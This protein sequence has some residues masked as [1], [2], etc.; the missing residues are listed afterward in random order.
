METVIVNSVG[1]ATPRRMAGRDYLVAP[2]AMIVPGVLNGSMGPLY[3]P[4]DELRMSVPSW[5]G[6][7]MVKN[8]PLKDGVPVSA[9]DPEVFDLYGLG[10]VYN[11][12]YDK[13]LKS[14]GWFDVERVG[15]VDGRILDALKNGDPIELSTGLVTRNVAAPKDAVYN[16]VPYTHVARDHRPDHLAVLPDGV[17]ACSLLD[18]CGVLVNSDGTGDDVKG[19]FGRFWD[20]ATGN[21]TADP[22]TLNPY[23]NEHAA[24]VADPGEFMKDTFR[25]KN[26]GPGLSAIMAKRKGAGPME[27]QSYRFSAHR[28][29]AK[30]AE[31]WLKKHNVKAKLEPASGTQNSSSDGEGGDDSMPMNEAQ[32]KA[33]VDFIT[34]NCSCWDRE[35]LN[36]MT[37]GQLNSVLVGSVGGVQPA[38]PQPTQSAAAPT[39]AEVTNQLNSVA[40]SVQ[41]LNA[42]VQSLVDQRK[43]EQET[44]KQT[45]IGN[46]LAGVEEPQKATLQATYN[47]MTVDQ[48]SVLV[49]N[50]PKPVDPLLPIYMQGGVATNAGS[51][52]PDDEP[53]DIPVVNYEDDSAFAAARK[54]QGAA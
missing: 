26:L 12:K 44:V 17:G 29:T 28:F 32:R 39:P 43:T 25:R 37:D 19:L 4:D 16:G 6:M 8:H 21:S 13:A 49:A 40:Q 51:S 35:T 30:E 36:K 50:K 14:E 34:V 48:L 27:V 1:K 23:P 24:R 10:H 22:L 18:G 3:Y 33:A 38:T 7:P 2:L 11:A 52:E 41:A 47:T 31:A 45:L 46:L 9:R 5:N 20:W 54:R 15:D 42:T 53:L